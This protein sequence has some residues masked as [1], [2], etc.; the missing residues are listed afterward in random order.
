MKSFAKGS[1][2]QRRL[3][4]II[5]DTLIRGVSVLA[6]PEAVEV[7]SSDAATLVMYSKA[8]YFT[9]NPTA[10]SLEDIATVAAQSRA[11]LIAKIALANSVEELEALLSEDPEIVAA[12]E[13]RLVEIDAFESDETVK[14]ELL[15]K[16]A[17]ADTLEALG[18]LIPEGE[19]DGDILAAAADRK[20]AL[21]VL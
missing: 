13:K 14:A 10:L 8:I 15:G 2:D 19:T 12:Y 4:V 21:T 17:A 16:I 11:E 18:T 6:D 3:V 1:D 20:T 7:D 9:A 5:A